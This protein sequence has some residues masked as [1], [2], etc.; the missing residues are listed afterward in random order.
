[1][2]LGY[3]FSEQLI[4]SR[5]NGELVTDRSWHYKPPGANDIP[6][7]FRV[8]FLGN[9]PNPGAGSLRAKG[10]SKSSSLCILLSN[11]LM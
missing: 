6:V 4:Y 3:W 11:T 7:D 10:N 5:E 8:K 9:S 1:M 2:G